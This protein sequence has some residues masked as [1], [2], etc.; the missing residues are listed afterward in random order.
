[1]TRGCYRPPKQDEESEEIFYFYLKLIFLFSAGRRVRITNPCSLEEFGFPDVCW[2]YN[3][4]EKKQS[5]R[6]L[7]YVKGNLLM[8]EVREPTKGGTCCTCFL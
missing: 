3:S 6:F 2:E 5:R 1:M 8:Q 7:E 4:A